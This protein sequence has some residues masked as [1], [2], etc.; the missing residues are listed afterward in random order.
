MATASPTTDTGAVATS[1]GLLDQL[2]IDT[3]LLGMVAALILIWIGFHLGTGGAFLTARNLWNLAVQ[4]SVVGV[5][6]TA[7]VFVIV[8]RNID[9]SIGSVLGFVGMIMAVVQTEWLGPALGFGNPVFWIAA[10]LIGLAAG[11]L[12]GA[13]QGAIVA[14]GRVPAFIVTLGGLLVFRGAAWWLTSGRTVAPMDETFEMIG[15]GLS[16]AIGGPASWVVGIVAAIA[17]VLGLWRTRARRQA[18]EF[19]VKPL[20]AELVVGAVAVA[21]ILGFVQVMNSYTLPTRVAADLL[22][23]RGVEVVAGQVPEIPRGIPIPVLIMIAAAVIMGFVAT[24]TRFGRYVY[25]IGGNPEAAQLA[26]VDTRKV[27]VVVF[28]LMGLLTAVSAAIATARLNAGANAT[29]T[30]AELQVIAAAVI[31]GTSLAGGAGTV[32]GALLGALVMQSLASGMVL[33]GLDT[34]LQNI[35]IG[36]V[37]VLAVFLDGIYQRRRR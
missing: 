3:R 21:L 4:T 32:A 36:L 5:M 10:L 17:V 35:V 31:G 7:M 22:R 27:I 19:P 24:R 2:D 30:L 12:I 1:R 9:L 37:L 13:S 16:G 29:G 23:A 14:Y 11:A 8:T 18:F 20:W 26:G 6:A 28:A 15:G 33:L 34:P 25:A